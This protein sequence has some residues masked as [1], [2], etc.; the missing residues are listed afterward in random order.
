MAGQGSDVNLLGVSWKE[1]I[2]DILVRGIF[3]K[4]SGDKMEGV[5]EAQS[6]QQYTA[7][8][9]RN[10]SFSTTDPIPTDGEDGDIVLIYA[11]VE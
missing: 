6:N 2:K 3:V 7:F 9:V 8:Q 10:I 11:P 4:K 5:L 1:F